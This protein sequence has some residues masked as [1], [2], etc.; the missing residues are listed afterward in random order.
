M[1]RL[2]LADGFP[3]D[4]FRHRFGEARADMLLAGASRWER[5]GLLTVDDDMGGKRIS[6]TPHGVMVSDEIIADLM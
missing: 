4:E 5:R 1:T 2:R 3:V 6:L